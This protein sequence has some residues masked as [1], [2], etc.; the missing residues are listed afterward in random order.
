[1]SLCL[2]CTFQGFRILK[3]F[4][5]PQ[6]IYTF[7]RIHFK[8]LGEHIHYNN[9]IYISFFTFYPITPIPCW[10]ILDKTLKRDKGSF[11]CKNLHKMDTKLKNVECL[12]F[13]YSSAYSLSQLVFAYFCLSLPV[14]LFSLL[15]IFFNICNKTGFSFYL[16][17][18]IFF[19]FP[20]FSSHIY[21]IKNLNNLLSY[22]S[23]DIFK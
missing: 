3:N 5:S 21:E 2:K 19:Y 8:I 23:F 10:L 22:N 9:N 1:M 18:F 4:F 7:Y 20:T 16:F 15:H 13:F 12:L 6:K 14:S 17:I 11:G